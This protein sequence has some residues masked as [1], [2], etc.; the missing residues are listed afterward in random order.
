LLNGVVS[1]FAA[2]HT[3][4]ISLTQAIAAGAGGYFIFT[5]NTS[6]T[7]VIGHTD[8][9]DG[10]AGPVVFG[11]TTAP[12]VTNA[13]T[14]LGGL[15]TLS[16]NL[17]SL[18]A[19]AISNSVEINW[20]T[21]A[22]ISNAYFDIERST[23][24]VRFTGIGTVKAGSAGSQ[25]NDYSFTDR[26]PEAGVNYY[27]LK[28]VD[29][30]GNFQYSKVVTANMQINALRMSTVYPNPVKNTLAWSIY[31][32]KNKEVLMQVSGISGNIVISQHINLV[33][34]KNAQLLNVSRLAA[35]SYLLSVAD[36]ETN[37]RLNQ[38]VVIIR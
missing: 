16:V 6:A 10:A 28:Q 21:T 20:T 35:G 27:R 33:K 36:P 29:L 23:D 2:P 15:Q 1:S 7:A 8:K 32:P 19:T 30:N 22:E 4:T 12:N 38:R 34:G 11:F 25:L 5:V 26:G 14:D 31:T 24:G 13:Q 9:V 3:Y 18:A 37:M 17:L